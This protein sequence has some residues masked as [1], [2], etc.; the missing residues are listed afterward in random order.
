MW[1]QRLKI[2]ARTSTIELPLGYKAAS[3][4]LLDTVSRKSFTYEDLR[5]ENGTV[6]MFICNH[7]PFVVLVRDQLVKLANEYLGKGIGFVVI[8]SNDA[9]NYPDDAPEKMK[10]LATKLNFPFTYLYDES[11]EVAKAYDAAC[12]PDFSVFDAND[13]CVYRGQLDD[14]RPGNELPSNGESLRKVFDCLINRSPIDIDQKPS[15]GCNI[16][17]K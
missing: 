10:H 11:Q 14:A 12:T 9:V 7:C 4:N 6:V 16:K 8:S 13:D 3:F 5:G 2:M 15:L 1:F 17:W